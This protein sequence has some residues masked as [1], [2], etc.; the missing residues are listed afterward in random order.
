MRAVPQDIPIVVCATG[1]Y[2]G[3]GF[4]ESRL[5]TLFLGM[6][7]SWEGILA[8][9]AGRLHRLYKNKT[10][11]RVYDYID[12]Q[13]GMLE[14]M[15]Y[16]RLK[17]YASL[18]YRVC[19]ERSDT[20]LTHDIIYDQRSFIEPF[21]SDIRNARHDI[22]IVSPFIKEKRVQWLFRAIQE[23]QHPL[24]IT[25]VTRPPEAFQQKASYE[26]FQAI[27]QLTLLGAKVMTKDAIHQKFAT[28][29]NK[30][31]WYGSINLLSFGSSQES[32]I[33]IVTGSIAEVLQKS[34]QS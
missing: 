15:Y 5:D 10:E 7:V 1:K 31:V 23:C 12:D 3:E 34:V 24:K 27:Q 29:D 32:M 16:K 21:L 20:Y 22:F 33:R 9:Y 11:V 6:P 19:G 8:Q 26:V 14:R 28:I 17:T 18:G 2:I 4:D 30:I 25:I 13:I